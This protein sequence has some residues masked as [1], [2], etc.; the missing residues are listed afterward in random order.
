MGVS[1]LRRPFG[2]HI[3]S[4]ELD[5]LVPSSFEARNE[6]RGLS[7]DVIK[8]VEHHVR[9]CPD[10]GRKVAKYRLIVSGPSKVA[11][12]EQGTNC[13]K[14]LEV[15]WHEVAAGLWPEFKARQLILHAALCDHCGA[16]L[17]AAASQDNTTARDEQRALTL[18]K[19]SQRDAGG[20]PRVWPPPGW[21]LMRWMA[22]AFALLA[23]VAVLS[24]I[25]RSSSGPLTGAG[26]AEFAVDTHR[27]LAQGRVGLDIRSDSQQTINQWFKTKSPFPV[28]LPVSAAIPGEERP[29][30]LQGARLVQVGGKTAAFISY[31]VQSPR[32][33]TAHMLTTEASLLVAPDSVAVASGGVEVHFRKV[34]FHYATV[35]GYKVVTWSVHGLTYA[36]V[37]NEGYDTQ[38]S[39]MVCHSA[40]RDR[41][42][43]QSSTPLQTKR[44]PDLPILE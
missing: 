28:A 14:G 13:P 24:T 17:R 39:C 8:E 6:V 42:L 22:P 33:R 11:R 36:L 3:D 1:E 18:K 16:L 12:S 5:A 44:N 34:S 4:Q 30:R 37:S 41:D 10:C 20:L 21:R 40:M 31:Q 38:R 35:G 32:L 2:K 19:P 43:S 29:Y 9:S 23:I 25:P 27:E 15:D 26:F 7:R